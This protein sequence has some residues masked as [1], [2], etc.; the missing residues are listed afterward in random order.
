[1]A[2]GFSSITIPPPH[3]LDLDCLLWFRPAHGIRAKG[4]DQPSGALSE[5]GLARSGE[6]GR[7]RLSLLAAV[8]ARRFDA[9]LRS[10]HHHHRRRE[11]HAANRRCS[12][13]SRR[14]PATTR[15]AA[16]RATGRPTISGAIETTGGARARRSVPRW[17]PKLTNGWFFRAESFF[18]VARYLD[19]AALE[20][21]G[22]PPP[23][24][25]SHS[26]GEGFLRF[27]EE[28]CQPAGT[29]HLRRAGI[30][31]VALAPDR[32]PETAPPHGR[33]GSSR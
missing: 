6:G 11:R 4:A 21:L 5:A 12:R 8:P 28:R 15:R 13:R 32:V 16:A 14:S 23:D 2:S 27:F 9:R 18:T 1:M 26:H 29:L 7:P 31:A 33:S 24:F 19:E 25:L 20:P 17:L 3:F 30:G 22:G 10:R